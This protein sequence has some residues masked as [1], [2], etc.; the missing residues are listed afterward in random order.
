MARSNSSQ[1]TLGIVLLAVGG[2]MLV[3]RFVALEAAPTW[4]LGLGLALALIA[5][6][7]RHYGSLVGGMVLLG[8]GAGMVLGDRAVA[9]WRMNTWILCGLAAGFVGV[10]LIALLLKLKSNPWP[11]IV[12][13]VLLAIVGARHLRE[14]T[15]LPPSV[16][17][18]M[19]TWWP[20][21]LVIAGLLLVFRG[22]RK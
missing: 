11:L 1:I 17:M 2:I 14:F 19:R 4:M 3:T 15:L 13:A 22:F 10:Y 5:I 20:A 9:G 16:V 12:A 21:A 8:L 7:R 6:L 18:A